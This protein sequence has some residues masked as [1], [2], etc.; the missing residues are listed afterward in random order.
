LKKRKKKKTFKDSVTSSHTQDWLLKF[1]KC[2]KREG[3][4]KK[5]LKGD[6][7]LQ[8]GGTQAEKMM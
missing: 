3:K 8:R 6:L 2:E 1:P 4:K 5:H 7:T